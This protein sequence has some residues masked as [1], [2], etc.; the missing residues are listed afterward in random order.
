MHGMELYLD[1]NSKQF[2]WQLLLLMPMSFQL[3]GVSWDQ[4][5]AGEN[6]SLLWLKILKNPCRIQV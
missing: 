3:K 4:K 5:M 1:H 6:V 2:P